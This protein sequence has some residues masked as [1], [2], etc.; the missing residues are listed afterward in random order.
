MLPYCAVAWLLPNVALQCQVTFRRPSRKSCDTD[1]AIPIACNHDE[2][3][4]LPTSKNYATAVGGL[5][6][7]DVPWRCVF[8]PQ[9]S[10]EFHYISG[11]V[12]PVEP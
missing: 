8:P 6:T 3:S 1:K 7:L 2:A 4:D 9:A 10:F 11:V 5:V 12:Y